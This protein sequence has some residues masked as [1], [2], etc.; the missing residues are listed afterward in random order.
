MSEVL[1]V[2]LRRMVDGD[3]AAGEEALRLTFPELRRIASGILSGESRADTLQPTALVNELYLRHLRGMT[4]TV[5]DRQH[6]YRLAGRGMRQILVDHAR[7]KLAAKRDAGR[8][9]FPEGLPHWTQ[10]SPEDVLSLDA[11][12]EKLKKVEARAAA[13][14][15]LRYILGCT[16]EETATVMGLA[17]RTVREDWDYAR[18]LLKR[19]IQTGR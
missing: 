5:Q 1:T 4:L 7:G 15:E 19:Y 12:M 18:V 2:L 17:V 6:F 11:A 14:V 8:M 16:L 13:V 10:L 9:P 3:A